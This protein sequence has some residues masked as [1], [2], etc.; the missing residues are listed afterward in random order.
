MHVIYNYMPETKNIIL[1]VGYILYY[2]YL[3]Y[4]NICTN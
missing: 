2:K 3:L 4:A 1:H